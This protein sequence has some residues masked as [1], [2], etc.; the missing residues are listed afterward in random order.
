MNRRLAVL[1]CL[2]AL[3]LGLVVYSRSSPSSAVMASSPATKSASLTPQIE[4]QQDLVRPDRRLPHRATSAA[5]SVLSSKVQTRECGVEQHSGGSCNQGCVSSATGGG[6][7]GCQ[8]S[9]WCGGAP[10]G[11]G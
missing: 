5:G 7:P 1:F 4:G 2:I 11:P 10:Q 8:G 6:E 9:K 3:V